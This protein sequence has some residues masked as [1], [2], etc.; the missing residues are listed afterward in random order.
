MTSILIVEDDENIR[1]LSDYILSQA[2]YQ[3][4]KAN[5]G[6]D[7]LDMMRQQRF[8]LI[9]LD[10]HMP[11]MSGLDVLRSVARPGVPMLPVLMVTANRNIDTVNE[12]MLLGCVGYVVKPFTPEGLLDR[13]RLA[14]TAKPKSQDVSAVRTALI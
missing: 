14:L 10:V 11:I 8:N 12:A 5:N 7:A 13:V 6:R 4:F 9:L 1:E 2:G 3:V